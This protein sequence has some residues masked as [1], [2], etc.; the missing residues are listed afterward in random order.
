MFSRD[1]LSLVDE[2]NRAAVKLASRHEQQ[3]VHGK[4]L[5]LVSIII[6]VYGKSIFTLNCLKSV[7]EQETKYSYEV[8]V[9]DDW[10]PDDTTDL[11]PKLQCVRYSKNEKNS[12]FIH[13]C[14]HGA[15]LAAGRFLLFLNNDSILLPGWLDELVDT[16][17]NFPNAGLVGSKLLYP[18]GRLQEAGCIIWN[19]GSAW[20]YGRNDDP[21]KPEYNYGRL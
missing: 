12:G 18:D 17:D 16:F 2:I 20:I 1:K 5:P 13:S 6:P 19:D 14:N 10:S 8:I 15:E 7:F 11:V 9:I 4:S 3:V 21:N